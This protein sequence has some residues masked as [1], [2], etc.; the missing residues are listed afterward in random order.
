MTK[1]ASIAYSANMQF[2]NV[3]AFLAQGI[4]TT[5]ESADTIGT[6]LKTV[7]GRFTEVKKAWSEGEL[8]A[9]IDGEEINV[10]NVSKALRTAGINM[11][12]FFTGA[13]G[14][15]EIFIE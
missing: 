11:N 3:A 2:E 5:R 1:T 8:K 15:D 13:R 4:E 12:D 9:E 7:I 10:N 6:M 14:L